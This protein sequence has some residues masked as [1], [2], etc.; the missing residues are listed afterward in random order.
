MRNGYA[1]IDFTMSFRTF[2]ATFSKRTCL[3][4]QRDLEFKQ[5]PILVKLEFVFDLCSS[6]FAGNFKNCRCRSK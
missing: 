1:W 3:V 5:K 6:Y 2:S 4:P